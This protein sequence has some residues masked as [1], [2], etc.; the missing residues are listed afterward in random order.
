MLFLEH[1]SDQ[2]HARIAMLR[3]CGVYDTVWICRPCTWS[4]WLHASP[5]LMCKQDSK[6]SC[7]AETLP[8]TLRRVSAGIAHLRPE[9]P[10]IFGMSRAQIL[11]TSDSSLLS[12][13]KPVWF[14]CFEDHASVLTRQYFNVDMETPFL[15]KEN[16]FADSPKSILFKTHLQYLGNFRYLRF[17]NID[18]CHIATLTSYGFNI[19]LNYKIYYYTTGPSTG[20]VAYSC[21]GVQHARYKHDHMQRPSDGTWTTV[22]W[23]L[24]DGTG[25]SMNSIVAKA[26]R[27]TIAWAAIPLLT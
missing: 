1:L 18:P 13:E 24:R 6:S 8:L 26:D 17:L 22:V 12:A 27:R 4:T 15:L 25:L 3:S 14:L 11:I 9:I 19:P 21:A 16:W 10:S 5:S 23:S 7:S 20:Q 2:R